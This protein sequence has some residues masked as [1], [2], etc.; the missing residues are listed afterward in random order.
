MAAVGSDNA[1]NDSS[2]GGSP[3]DLD[4]VGAP[5]AADAGVNRGEEQRTLRQ[6]SHD[7]EEL[8]KSWLTKIRE[9]KMEKYPNQ[10]RNLLQSLGPLPPPGSPSARALWHAALIN[11][12]PAIGLAPEIRASV[13]AATGDARRQLL[14]VHEALQTSM[15]YIDRYDQLKSFVHV[16]L[17][18]SVAILCFLF[19]VLRPHAKGG[20]I[21]KDENAHAVAGSISSVTDVVG[22]F[23]DDPEL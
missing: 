5:A 21:L 4:V 6:L 11:P 17:F 7:V 14:I 22:T 10:L 9:K 12:I 2:V 15:S 23:L 18:V 19:V 16:G 20:A 8:G 3:A 13:L 1:L